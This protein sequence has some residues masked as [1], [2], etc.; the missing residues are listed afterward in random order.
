MPYEEYSVIDSEES[1]SQRP[2]RLTAM[3]QNNSDMIF[4]LIYLSWKTSSLNKLSEICLH[5]WATTYVIE[6][7]KANS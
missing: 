5:Y 2:V 4:D 6:K 3:L 1:D 7:K